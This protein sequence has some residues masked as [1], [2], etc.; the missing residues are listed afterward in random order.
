VPQEVLSFML[1]ETSPDMEEE[2]ELV[3][4]ATGS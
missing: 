1:G 4:E 3:E 2:E